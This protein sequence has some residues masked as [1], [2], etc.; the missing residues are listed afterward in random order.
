MTDKN[1]SLQKIVEEE[2]MKNLKNIPSLGA[3][4][5]SD[6]SISLS[7]QLKGQRKRNNTTSDV[8][9]YHLS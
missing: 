4:L 9:S 2:M 8:S 3:N 1:E 5:Q 6:C 7:P